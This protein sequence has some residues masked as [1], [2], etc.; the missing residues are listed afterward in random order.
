MFGKLFVD[1]DD[2]KVEVIFK[3]F[4]ISVDEVE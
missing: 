1:V 3:Y 2:V 4:N